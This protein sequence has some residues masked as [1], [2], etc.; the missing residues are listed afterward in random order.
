[1]LAERCALLS[2]EIL[3]SQGKYSETATL[4]IKMTSEVRNTGTGLG[5]GLG[6]NQPVV[7]STALLLILYHRGVPQG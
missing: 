6:R 3:K 1:M 7:G 2:A 5:L 4:L